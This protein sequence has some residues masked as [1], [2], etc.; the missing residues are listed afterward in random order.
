MTFNGI[1]EFYYP[2]KNVSANTFKLK[3]KRRGSTSQNE[4]PRKREDSIFK[5]VIAKGGL[6]TTGASF[7]MT[8]RSI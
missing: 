2:L 4:L 8:I 6:P 7:M 1:V 5:I 3:P